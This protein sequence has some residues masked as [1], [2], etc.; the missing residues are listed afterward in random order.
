MEDVKQRRRHNLKGNRQRQ[1][2]LK[3]L[4]AHAMPGKELTADMNGLDADLQTA[5]GNIDSK[6]GR[7]S[8]KHSKNMK[9]YSNYL[10]DQH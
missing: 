10:L 4:S 8:M 1:S 9:A 6:N 5:T 7:D 3:D 2:A